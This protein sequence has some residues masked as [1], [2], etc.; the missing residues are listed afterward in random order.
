MHFAYIYNVCQMHLNVFKN[1]I[2]INGQNY[3]SKFKAEVF[4][5]PNPSPMCEVDESVV[6]QIWD[7]RVSLQPRQIPHLPR[8][9][10]PVPPVFIT[11]FLLFLLHISLIYHVGLQRLFVWKLLIR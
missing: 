6:F 4:Q 3:R 9:L 2:W 1:A 5:E 11:M 8:P 10:S 7:K